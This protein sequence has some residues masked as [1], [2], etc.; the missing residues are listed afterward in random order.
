[1]VCLYGWRD[2]LSDNNLTLASFDV[3][4][5][6][7]DIASP[8]SHHRNSY[9]TPSRSEHAYGDWSHWLLASVSSPPL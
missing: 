4:D 5:E 2:L 1:M 9:H 6:D 8:V 3:D 7:I